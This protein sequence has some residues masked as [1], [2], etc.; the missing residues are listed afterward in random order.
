MVDP[1]M[2]Y[3]GVKENPASE[4]IT[5]LTLSDVLNLTRGNNTRKN[6]SLTNFLGNLFG[7][8]FASSTYTAAGA[9]AATDNLALI[10]VS[11]AVALTI[12]APAAGRFL[13]IAQISTPTCATT[14][15][16]T[17]GTFRAA[18]ANKATFNAAEEALILYGISATQFLIVANVGAVALATV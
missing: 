1:R 9:I 16:L 3:T 12:A 13:V 5:T 17:A 6:I 8:K 7:V 18:G 2:Y 4:A 11:T 14:V 10:N 15:T